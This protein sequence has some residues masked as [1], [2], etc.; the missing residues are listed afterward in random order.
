M[1]TLNISL[2][3]LRIFLAVAEHHGFSR[4]GS[5]IGLTQS[6][7]S[8]NISELETELGIRLFDRTT[9]E[10]LLTREGFELSVELRRLLE[11]LDATL[12]NAC[13]KREH[14][15]GS[16]HVATSPTISAGIMPAC[17]IKVIE[18][19]KQINL[20]IHDQAQKQ[21]IQM[22][23]NGE[24]DFG[25]IVEP[26]TDVDLYS[27]TCLEEPFCL[28]MPRTHQMA[29]MKEIQWHDLQNQ[30]LVLLDYASGSRPLIDNALIRH[31]VVP[32]VIQE[33]GH[34]STI[35]RLLQSGI[36]V[37]VI[38]QLAVSS[39]NTTELII[40]ELK[41]VEKRRLQLVRRHNRALSPAAITVW[42]VI[43]QWCFEAGGIIPMSS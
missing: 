31:G 20:I 14:R 10:V 18:N 39:L 19:N 23:L 35:F 6:A 41:P 12:Q 42:E 40:R 2:R 38:P 32:R 16:V 27:E 29:Q 26:T 5:M 22:V 7:M 21:T 9:R 37:S 3:Q 30:D 11:E 25:V 43:R 4:A 15:S 33:L 1:N 8:H 28:I 13:D 24:V 36:G 17:I 34:V